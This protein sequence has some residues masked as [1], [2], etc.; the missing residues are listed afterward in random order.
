MALLIAT[1]WREGP[2]KQHIK[3]AKFSGERETEKCGLLL[4][5][6]AQGVSRQ[7]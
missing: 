6:E 7:T 5:A 4:N 2:R 3:Q 1:L